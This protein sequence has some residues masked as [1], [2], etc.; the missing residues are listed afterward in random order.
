MTPEITCIART[1]NLALKEIE[2]GK[3]MKCM[4]QNKFHRE[5]CFVR[6]WFESH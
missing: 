6:E 4:I 5:E 3:D 1:D 2:I